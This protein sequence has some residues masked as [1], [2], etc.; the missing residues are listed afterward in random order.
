MISVSCDSLSI[1]T[2]AKKGENNTVTRTRLDLGVRSCGVFVVVAVIRVNT[3]RSLVSKRTF[4]HCEER[5]YFYCRSSYQTCDTLL[6]EVWGIVHWGESIKRS[7]TTA[8]NAHRFLPFSVLLGFPLGLPSRCG[9]EAQHAAGLQRM[10][11]RW[12]GVARW[13]RVS[14]WWIRFVYA[15]VYR[16]TLTPAASVNPSAG[17]AA[18][19]AFRPHFNKL[20]KWKC[21]RCRTSSG[22]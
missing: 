19:L 14:R 20:C 17:L 3:R 8:W 18:G 9:S 15:S 7:R 6:R 5:M 11:S 10:Q 22:S 1:S 2:D 4:V 16:W 13:R 12:L 21:V